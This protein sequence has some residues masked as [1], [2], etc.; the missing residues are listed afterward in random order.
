MHRITGE[1]C[2]EGGIGFDSEIPAEE[3]KRAPSQDGCLTSY[4]A[5]LARC[6]DLRPLSEAQAYPWK[7]SDGSGHHEEAVDGADI[8]L[9]LEDSN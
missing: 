7:A 9:M 6:V 4:K 2:F 3:G 5:T 1:F 8:V